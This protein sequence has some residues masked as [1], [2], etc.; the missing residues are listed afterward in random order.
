MYF[1]VCKQHTNPGGCAS[2][3][4]IQREQEQFDLLEKKWGSKIVRRDTGNAAVTRKKNQGYDIN[5]IIKVPIGG[6]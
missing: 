2:Y 5:P 3:R 1:Y 4:T 6:V